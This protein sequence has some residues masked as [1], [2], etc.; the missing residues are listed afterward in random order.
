[1]RLTLLISSHP[2]VESAIAFKTASIRTLVARPFHPSSQKIK[3]I[4]Q[5]QQPASETVVQK[6]SLDEWTT[7]L[8]Q[9]KAGRI[10]NGEPFSSLLDDGFNYMHESY[11]LVIDTKL[12]EKKDPVAPNVS[13]HGDKYVDAQQLSDYLLE[14]FGAQTVTTTRKSKDAQ[15]D[16][17]TTQEN[18]ESIFGEPNV[19]YSK[20]LVDEETEQRL[21]FLSNTSSAAKEFNSRQLGDGMLNKVKKVWKDAVVVARMQPNDNLSPQDIVQSLEDLLELPSEYQ[22][23]CRIISSTIG[24]EEEASIDWCAQVQTTWSPSVIIGGSLVLVIAFP[25]HTEEDCQKAV[26]D[27]TGSATSRFDK[28]ILEGGA[29]F[30][31]G[32]HPTT[33]MCSEWLIR[34]VSSWHQEHHPTTKIDD[35]NYTNTAGEKTSP[36]SFRVMDYGSGS[37]ILGI[38]AL[39]TAKRQLEQK[40][41]LSDAST[42]KDT[43]GIKVDAVEVDM[44]A[45]DSAKR[46]VILNCIPESIIDFYTPMRGS[47]GWS[48]EESLDGV[49]SLPRDRTQSYHL[50][51]ANIMSQPLIELSKT[52]SLLTKKNI[53]KIGLSGIL[54]HQADAVMDAYQPYFNDI[55]ITQQK[56]GWILLEGR[57]N[58]KDVA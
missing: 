43:Y 9:H 56:N 25:F 48:Q 23:N 3:A 33:S 24:E 47:P 39:I 14:V 27:A 12:N 38:V 46:N 10:E 19:D 30:G 21:S 37:G 18:D 13:L 34:E 29:A 5:L 22:L 26:K 28:I 36:P 53:G 6:S 20:D 2:Q 57:R 32:D 8:S 54:I 11:D 4:K 40:R 45:I 41:G 42:T 35:D 1:M 55:Q 7:G 17:S 31:T 51:V 44:N 16:D 49:P 15:L 52:L 50:V 58:N